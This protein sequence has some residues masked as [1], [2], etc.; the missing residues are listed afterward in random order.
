MN[1]A[2]QQLERTR[3]AA[4]QLQE[5]IQEMKAAA[6]AIIGRPI[7]PELNVE[8]EKTVKADTAEK[9]PANTTESTAAPE[10]SKEVQAPR[11]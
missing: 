6:A 4:V 11:L 5:S 1:A 2:V 8:K 7:E 9:T 3:A 10:P